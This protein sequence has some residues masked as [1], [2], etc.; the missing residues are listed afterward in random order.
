MDELI[1]KLEV[2]TDK[3]IEV[4]WHLFPVVELTRK[5]GTTYQLSWLKRSTAYYASEL[6]LRLKNSRTNCVG[7]ISARGPESAQ[8]IGRL[9]VHLCRSQVATGHVHRCA[10]KRHLAMTTAGWSVERLQKWT[11]D[12][13]KAFDK[14]KGP[15]AQIYAG[16]DEHLAYSWPDGHVSAWKRFYSGTA[17]EDLGESLVSGEASRE[18]ERAES[19]NA[20]L[21]RD[22]E[23][24]LDD[25]EHSGEDRGDEPER[26]EASEGGGS[27]GGA[28][29]EGGAVGG[30]AGDSDGGA[31]GEGV[32]GGEA[33]E[34]TEPTATGA[35]GGGEEGGE[36]GGS[37]GRRES[38]VGGWG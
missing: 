29:G 37:G 21:T 17:G 24:K 22:T 11:T 14:K 23:M 27:G 32:R 9:C 26:E 31:E 38:D 4:N 25:A 16:L 7:C 36:P 2:V 6:L 1:G 12:G 10:I 15:A 28:G 8:Y 30:A 13:A 19:T 20:G 18:E 5:D 34:L 3:W 33:T 35:G